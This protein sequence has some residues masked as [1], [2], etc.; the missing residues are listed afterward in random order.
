MIAHQLHDK[1]IVITGA[2]SGVGRAIARAAGAQ[3]AKV[4]LIARGLDGLRAA[5]REVER[6]GGSSLVLPLDVSD[7]L[8]VHAAAQKIVETW[9]GIDAWI[10]NAMVS[11]FA[12]IASITPKEYRRVTEVNYLG[13]VHGT[14]AALEH[15]RTRG[16]GTIVQIGSALVYRSIPLQAAYCASKAAIRG[17]TDSLRCE[18]AH[19][20]SA[21][22]VTMLQLP[23]VN[24]PQFQVV[25]NKLPA[26]A[27]PVPPTYQPE[28]I[29]D[30]ALYALRHPRRE[31]WI[32][33]TTLKAI[34]GQWVIPGVL[35]RYLGKMAWAAQTTTDIAPS[36]GDNLY[37]PLP[38]DRGAHGLFDNEARA[39]N[40]LVWLRVH[41]ATA[42]LGVV[43][44][45]LLIAIVQKLSWFV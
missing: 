4:A 5:A 30:A 9:G 33:W 3:H 42:L 18:L 40:T 1:V 12:P 2:S 10:N 13:T 45:T 25:K 36:R 22:K 28:V 16:R 11:V 31:M 35:D 44:I 21:I 8:A 14:L 32:G 41:L 37:A 27:R 19:E 29:A 15:M 39:V 23:A 20:G 38:G 24:T 17:F 34:V 6:A 7:S 26:H 43:L